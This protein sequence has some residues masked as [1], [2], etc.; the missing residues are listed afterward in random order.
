M[1]IQRVMDLFTTHG[2][3]ILFVIVFLEYLNLPGF[4]SGII[5]PAAGILI[6]Q[7]N[8][9]F[10]NAIISTL[11]AGVLGSVVLYYAGYYF[12]NPIL[13]WMGARF[14]KTSHSIDKTNQY[15]EKYGS[16]GVFVARLIPV[17][18]TLISLVAGIFRMHPLHYILY[19][20]P[21]IFLW[22]T[23]YIFAGYAF[24]DVFLG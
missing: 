11:I 10:V 23:A 4:P 6:A 13:S 7:A 14:P 20:T 1:D 17:A 18:R 8:L 12:G 21:G 15:I 2:L 9:S 19:S 5:M 22:N 3:L 16:K 24:A